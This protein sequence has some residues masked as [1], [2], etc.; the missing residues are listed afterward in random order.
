[1]ER[2]RS[3]LKWNLSSMI[4]HL[5]HLSAIALSCKLRLLLGRVP[6]PI[7][8][9]SAA[10]Q[11]FWFT[12]LEKLSA[13]FV[14]VDSGARVRRASSKIYHSHRRCWPGLFLNYSLWV[15]GIRVSI[16][17]SPP[18][19]RRRSFLL[20]NDPQIR[21]ERTLARPRSTQT[22]FTTR[23]DLL[24]NLFYTISVS[25]ERPTCRWHLNT[26][27]IR[28]RIKSY[29]PPRSRRLIVFES[30]YTFLASRIHF[31]VRRIIA[32]R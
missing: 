12:S 1:M 13:E 25:V 10:R 14:P 30:K 21:P 3:S 29:A 16:N 32:E 6:G 28:P 11:L 27:A 23:R 8:F 4:E 5:R 2:T 18:S 22:T 7:V 24:G 9:F 31:I 26:A 15:F 20:A 17:S 19:C